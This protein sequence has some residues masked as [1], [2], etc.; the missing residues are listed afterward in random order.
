MNT[1]SKWE[2]YILQREAGTLSPRKQRALQ[3]ALAQD[4]ELQAYE[5]TLAVARQAMTDADPDKPVSAFTLS[6]II[7]EAERHGPRI[8]DPTP[9]WTLRI[10]NWK[11][12][13]V[14]GG[15]SVLVLI[16]GSALFFQADRSGPAFQSVQSE[17]D[18]AGEGG[19]V[20][21]WDRVFAEEYEALAQQLHTLRTEASEAA[22][23][24]N[25]RDEEALAR[26]LLEWEHST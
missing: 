2:S 6:R 7:Q 23:L 15:L 13:L 19:A 24:I 5:R 1:P 10:P 20:V 22:W 26:E 9:S 8:P 11:P 4:P 3:R 25:D 21:E 17:P 12:A 18:F 16:L 14:Y